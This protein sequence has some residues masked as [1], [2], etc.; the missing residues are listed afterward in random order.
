MQSYEERK[1]KERWT[2][3]LGV[4]V[5]KSWGGLVHGYVRWAVMG[6]APGPDGAETM[7]ILGREEVLKRLERAAEVLVEREENQGKE[8]EK[9]KTGG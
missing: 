1:G 9:E 4:A 3:E 6:E 2:E 8:L 5:R 7:R